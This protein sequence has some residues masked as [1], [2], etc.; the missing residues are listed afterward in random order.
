MEYLDPILNFVFGGTSL[1]C[2]IE[3]VRFRKENKTLKKAEA[4][5]ADVEAQISKMELGDKYLE[6]VLDLS[7]R[8]YQATL[9]NN[10]DIN[11][12]FNETD[13]RL[14]KVSAEVASIVRYLG[15]DYQARQLAGSIQ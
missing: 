7:E 11:A 12:R 3:A 2:I 13:R 6:K 1:F 15:E 4:S 5:K 8:S 10:E 14:D 9:K